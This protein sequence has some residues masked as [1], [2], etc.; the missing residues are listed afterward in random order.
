M[1]RVPANNVAINTVYRGRM[2][3]SSQHP[4]PAF[5]HNT[6]LGEGRPSG[7]PLNGSGSNSGSVTDGNRPPI[8]D[9]WRMLHSRLHGA[10]S[11]PFMSICFLPQTPKAIIHQSRLEGTASFAEWVHVERGI[12]VLN[13]FMTLLTDY[14][15]YAHR[16][17]RA[18]EVLAVCNSPESTSQRFAGPGSM[19]PPRSIP[20]S[21]NATPVGAPASHG[22]NNISTNTA[23][24][25]FNTS[26]SNSQNLYMGGA[27]GTSSQTTVAQVQHMAAQLRPQQ[28]GQPGG[29]QQSTLTTA[30]HP[31]PDHTLQSSQNNTSVNPTIPAAHSHAG[32]TIP[33]S[34]GMPAPHINPSTIAP[35]QQNIHGGG[36]NGVS[37]QTMAAQL[38]QQQTRPSG[39]NQQP[40]SSAI[41]RLSPS[42]PSQG[43]QNSTSATPS[44]PSR[45]RG[46]VETTIH[47]TIETINSRIDPST[48]APTRQN[49]DQVGVNGVSGHAMATQ[50]QQRQTSQSD[51]S[52]QS[53]ST[54]PNHSIPN[55]TPQV[56]Q[57]NTTATSTTPSGA[58]THVNSTAPL[59]VEATNSRIDSNIPKP[60]QA[61][62]E[63]TT[64]VTSPVTALIEPYERN[65]RLFFTN[66]TTNEISSIGI[67]RPSASKSRKAPA[68]R[69]R[70]AAAAGI[71][72]SKPSKP[73]KVR[74]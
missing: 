42:T 33:P 30:H 27:S 66:T 63:P 74:K 26:T 15:S 71:G 35:N 51:G 4:H 7:Q 31:N 50:L 39:G 40:T 69:K 9:Y 70:N 25:A 24:S 38:Q 12:G 64:A 48:V 61:S 43:S 52:Q 67:H 54:M 46:H 45:A 20:H 8:S 21:T 65:G 68:G 57:S 28:M 1:P 29:N 55:P 19:P 3:A 5:D 47:S 58:H 22:A 41:N 14:A 13:Y 60:T 36:A 18:L 34:A 23:G 62:V 10:A 72:E 2:D 32:T 17:D 56:S 49:P 53:S 37:S 59:S 73:N 16:T 6:Y 11:V 44:S